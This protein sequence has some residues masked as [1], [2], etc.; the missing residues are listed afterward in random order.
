MES[1]VCSLQGKLVH[2]HI[3]SDLNVREHWRVY[4]IVKRIVVDQR[5]LA[6][7]GDDELCERSGLPSQHLAR[8][9]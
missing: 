4:V 6:G 5:G 1:R 8:H 9:G 3:A 7:D 2:R